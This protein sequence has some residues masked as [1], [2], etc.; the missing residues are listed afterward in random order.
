MDSVYGLPMNMVRQTGQKPSRCEG[1][2]LFE[3]GDY[4]YPR[5]VD[6]W[7]YEDGMCQ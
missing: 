5:M 4:G 3:H 2:R 1:M 6:K 7:R